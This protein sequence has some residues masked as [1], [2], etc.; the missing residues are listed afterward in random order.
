LAKM[1]TMFTIQVVGLYPNTHKIGCD[2]FTDTGNLSD[3]MK[4]FTKT[5]CQ[6]GLM[7]LESDGKTPQEKFNPEWLVNRAQ[8]GTILS[9]LIYSD[10]YN[11][12]SGEEQIYKWYEKHLTALNKDSIM[13]KIQDPLMLEK[14]ARVLIMLERTASANL[15]EQYHLIPPTHNWALSLLEHVW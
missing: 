11:I 4:F 6:L 2:A 1:M 13:N 14:R 5:A 8:F 15:V 10:Q 3:E 7:G 9:R 12:Y